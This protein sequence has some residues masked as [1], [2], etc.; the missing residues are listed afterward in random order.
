MANQQAKRDD[1]RMTTVLGITNDAN[2]TTK[3]LIV[4]PST[5][6]VKVSAMNFSGASTVHSQPA[7]RDDNRRTVWCGISDADGT[8]IIPLAID[9]VNG[10]LYCVIN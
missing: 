3:S 6:Y 2:K 5:G 4:D 1:N 10:F 8:T 9:H 7:A